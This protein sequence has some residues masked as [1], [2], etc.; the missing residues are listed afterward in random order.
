MLLRLCFWQV[1]MSEFMSEV[2]V[3]INIENMITHMQMHTY[4]HIY[5]NT[6]E[7]AKHGVSVVSSVKHFQ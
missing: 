3:G 7:A 1:Q 2:E 6:R 4:E 5:S